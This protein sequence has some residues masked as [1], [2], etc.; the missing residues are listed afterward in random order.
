MTNQLNIIFDNFSIRLLGYRT[1][2]SFLY[3]PQGHNFLSTVWLWS[4]DEVQ[5]NMYYFF[6]RES[7]S[8]RCWIRKR[9]DHITNHG[10]FISCNHF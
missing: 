8:L 7:L 10:H 3:L 4:T 9:I 1:E 2:F 6:L 5:M